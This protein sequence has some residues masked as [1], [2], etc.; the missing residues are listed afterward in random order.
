MN[1]NQYLTYDHR[2]VFFLNLFFKPI[3][4][5]FIVLIHRTIKATVNTMQFSL[6][7]PKRLTTI[8]GL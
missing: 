8:E 1:G 7:R 6:K 5:V 4:F 3:L 2:T